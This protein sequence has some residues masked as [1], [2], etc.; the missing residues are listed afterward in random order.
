VLGT[1]R[2]YCHGEQ[3]VKARRGQ[4]CT[5]FPLEASPQ[6]EIV[7]NDT[8]TGSYPLGYSTHGGAGFAEAVGVIGGLQVAQTQ[9]P[10]LS[11]M[12]KDQLDCVKLA[13]RVIL[14]GPAATYSAEELAKLRRAFGLTD[15]YGRE[16]AEAVLM[17]AAAGCGFFAENQDESER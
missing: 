11:H 10:H 9:Q 8:T 16:C 12:S 7:A 4:S 3:K 15:E 6:L 17:D 13:A 14:A 2:L 5:P 1:R